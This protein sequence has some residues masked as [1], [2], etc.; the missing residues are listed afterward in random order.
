MSDKFAIVSEKCIS[1]QLPSAYNFKVCTAHMF[2]LVLPNAHMFNSLLRIFCSILSCNP[3]QI[4]T[5]QRV[6]TTNFI[7]VWPETSSSG[8]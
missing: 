3:D 7:A 6:F 8:C 2:F 1:T 5:L 4:V